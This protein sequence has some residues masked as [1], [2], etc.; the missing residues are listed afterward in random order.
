M[1]AQVEG[2]RHACSA[3]VILAG[4]GAQLGNKPSADE[5]GPRMRAQ[6]EGLRPG[7]EYALRVRAANAR[8][9][10]PWSVLAAAETLP[11]PPGPP[12]PP[13]LSQRT[14]SSVRCRWEPP[15]EDN[16]AAV[17]R[18]RRGRLLSSS[19]GQK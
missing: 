1:R 18:Y 15:A 7:R 11:A 2:L 10:G 14:S 5:A 3:Q 17:L 13:G 8:G 19:C 16:G 12:A 6:V 4:L 9:Q